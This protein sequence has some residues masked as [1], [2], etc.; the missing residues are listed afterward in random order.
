MFAGFVICDLV[1][2]VGN[3]VDEDEGIALDDEDDE[4]DVDD[5]IEYFLLNLGG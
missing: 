4:K 3:R 1:E 5:D 2:D